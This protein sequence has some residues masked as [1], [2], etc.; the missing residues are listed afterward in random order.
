MLEQRLYEYVND[1]ENPE[2]NYNLAIEYENIGQTASALSFFLRCADRSG[3]DLDLAYECLIHIGNCFDKQGN[4]TNHA[5]GAYKQ[6]ISILPRRPEAY[7]QI[8][9]LKNWNSLFDDGYSYSSIALTICDF[10]NLKPLKNPINYTGKH[11]LLF[12]KALSSWWWGKLDECK[13]IL[14]YLCE[15]CWES[16][17]DYQKRNI[18]EYLEKYYSIN[19]QTIINNKK[20][21]NIDSYEKIDIVLQ[22][23][24]I[25]FTNE[26][27][28]D[29]YKLPFVNKIIL[30]CWEN[31]AVEYSDE[32]KIKIVYNKQ[33]STSGTDN[34][35]LQI[36]TSLNGLKC[37]N[38]DYSIK[39]RTDQK[40]TYDSMMNMYSFFIQNK[41][42]ERIFVPGMY[43]HLLFHPRDHV[44]WGKTE[45]LLKMFDIPLEINGLTDRVKISKNE[46]WK[47]YE[48]FVRSETYIG[49]HYCS[50]YDDRIKLFLIDPQK[51]LF[52]NAPNWKEAYEVSKQ[53]SKRIFKSFPKENIDLIWPNKNWETYPYE[54]QYKTGER[55]HEDGV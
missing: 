28:E 34:R 27:I 33:P 7:Y 17:D 15:N 37:V 3:D 23:K 52:D 51:Y 8:C 9:R 12:E 10:D 20:I 2:K 49:A 5:Y 32:N 46:L 21:S 44:F 42:E 39:M 13:N 26:I 36:I 22:G 38:T 14:L 35:N 53:L 54:N 55:W 29:Y 6:A 24:Y 19:A 43:P 16:L 31:D 4:R 40:Y 47:Y 30:S 50:N 1:V 41:N 48:Y 25:E 18:E 11:C 45:S